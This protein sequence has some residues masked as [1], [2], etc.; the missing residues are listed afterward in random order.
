MLVRLYLYLAGYP[1]VGGGGLH[2]AHMIW[3]ALLMVIALVIAISFVGYA[4]RWATAVVGGLGF[5]LL[6]DEVGKFL[7]SDNNYFF[8]PA[9]AIIYVS[10]MAL[11]LTARAIARR[12]GF[13]AEEYLANALELFEEAAA[14]DLDSFERRK[15]VHLLAQSGQSPLANR[16][17]EILDELDPPRHAS[18]LQRWRLSLERRYERLARRPRFL[19]LVGFLVLVGSIATFAEVLG[20][21]LQNDWHQPASAGGLVD[22]TGDFFRAIDIVGWLELLASLASVGLAVAGVA[23][24]GASRARG[25]RMLERAILLWI[26]IVQPFAFYEAQFFAS[27][28]LLLS[29]AMWSCV[30]FALRQ[31]TR[32]ERAPGESGHEE[33]RQPAHAP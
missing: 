25:L 16:L 20:I 32:R 6:I 10:F 5:G 26:L 14:G 7:T 15:L 17:R 30:Q 11:F 27:A 28:G 2:V 19:R 9:A 23:L 1:K 13:S 24:F 22:S 8:K 33:A 21:L 3:G 12:A 18:R 31:E 29:L 4:A